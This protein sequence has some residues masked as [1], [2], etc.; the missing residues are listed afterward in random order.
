MKCIFW[1]VRGLNH[2]LKQ[3][4]VK[5]FLRLHKVSLLTLVETK[6]DITNASRVS[7][8]ICPN[9]Q[10]ITNYQ[11]HHFG[12]I[13]VLW[14]PHLFDVEVLLQSAQFIHC[15]HYASNNEQERLSLWDDLARTSLSSHSAP[16]LIGR[17]MNEVRYAF[18][19]IGGRPLLTENSSTSMIASNPV[20]FRTSKLLGTY[21]LGQTFSNIVFPLGWT[22]LSSITLAPLFPGELHTL[23]CTKPI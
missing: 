3:L 16:W 8:H 7:Q 10:A 11:S 15:K 4:D 19:K 21:F 1:N 20:T 12:R 18:E 22:A 13:W 14:D 6:V 9:F 23:P 17:D 2:L 5:E